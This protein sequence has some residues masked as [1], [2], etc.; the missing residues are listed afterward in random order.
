MLSVQLLI[1]DSMMARADMAPKALGPCCRR[2]IFA[3]KIIC[4]PTAV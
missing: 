3:N 4:Q 2:V 1:R